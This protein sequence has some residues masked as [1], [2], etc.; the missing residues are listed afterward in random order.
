M[1]TIS[2]CTMLACGFQL[3]FVRVLS[4][5]LSIRNYLREI[6][7]KEFKRLTPYRSAGTI[8]FTFVQ[9]FPPYFGL[10]KIDI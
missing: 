5:V 8:P 9:Y 10:N 2:L 4:V 3:N 6:L 7:I 1:I